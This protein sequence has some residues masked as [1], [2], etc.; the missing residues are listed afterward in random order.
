MTGEILNAYAIISR[1]RAYAG[2]TGSPLPLS[3]RDIEQYLSV[4]PIKIDRD[5]FEAAIFALDD[6]WRDEWAKKQE[7]DRKKK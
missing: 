4:R 5:E 2:M 6:A 7:Q 1:S 3:I